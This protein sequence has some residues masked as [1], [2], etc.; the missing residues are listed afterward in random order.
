MFVYTSQ[1]STYLSVCI[2]YFAKDSD[3]IVLTYV[4]QVQNAQTGGWHEVFVDAD[5]GQVV[6]LISFVSNAKVRSYDICSSGSK[7]SHKSSIA[8][9][10]L[11]LKIPRTDSRPWPTR[12]IRI[13]P[14]TVGINTEERRQLQHPEIMWL[15]TRQAQ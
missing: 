13:L 14:L 15:H 2:Q 10:L 3:H 5:S 7:Y 9:F 12:M 8:L 4:I 6:N 1:L 11:L